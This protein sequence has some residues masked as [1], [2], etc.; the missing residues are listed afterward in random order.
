VNGE[1]GAT[2]NVYGFPLYDGA[3]KGLKI[4]HEETGQTVD[5]NDVPRAL[6][7]GEAE[8]MY[9]HYIRPFFPDVGPRCLRHEVCL[10]T[11][12]PGDRFIIDWHPTQKGVVFV[13]ACSGHGFKHSAAIGEAAAHM[14]LD[15]IRDGKTEYADLAPFSIA[16]FETTRKEQG[17]RV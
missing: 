3:V 4:T 1:G 15:D 2:S 7:A 6:L 8:H 13:S 11:R 17:L 10:Y 16:C 5:P 14:L 9:E 12:A